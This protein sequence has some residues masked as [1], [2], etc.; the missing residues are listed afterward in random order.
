MIPGCGGGTMMVD[1]ARAA[2]FKI[3][4]VGLLRW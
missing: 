3:K 1:I 4:R 2:P